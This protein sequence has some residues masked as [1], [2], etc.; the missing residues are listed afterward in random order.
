MMFVPRPISLALLLC[1]TTSMALA[2]SPSPDRRYRE[3]V[4]VVDRNTG[5]AHFTRGM[6]SYT[7]QALQKAVGPAD[8]P[9]LRRMLTDRDRVVVMTTVE[10]LMRMDA[11]GRRAVYEVLGTTDN[12]TAR[13]TIADILSGLPLDQTLQPVIPT[14]KT[15]IPR[16]K[17]LAECPHLPVIWAVRDLLR[18][19]GEPGLAAIREIRAAS[20]HKLTRDQ[21]KE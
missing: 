9:V 10:V 21:M 12:K 20:P 6:N 8:L 3:L 18:G 15:D 13:D 19:M 11:T 4:K 5:H 14:W 7:I 16:L 17:E 1:L 2:M